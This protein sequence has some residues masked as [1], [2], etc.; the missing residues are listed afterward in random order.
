[1]IVDI[2]EVAATPEAVILQFSGELDFES[3]KSLV[4]AF[5][6]IDTSSRKYAIAEVGKISMISS[7]ALGEFMGFRKTL[8]EKDGDLVFAAMNMDIRAKFTSMGATKIFRIFNDVRSALNAFKWQ[9]GL[10]PEVINLTFPANLH[11]VPPVRQLASRIA[12]Q[13]GYGNKDS[14]RI[15]TI[16][17]EICNNA[18]EHGKKG[19]DQN[20]S[21]KIDIDQK[22]IEFDV[23]NTSDPEK[24]ETLKALL[25]PTHEQK[26]H[27]EEKRGR[28]LS[29]IK[30]L[31]DELS[32][33][34]SEKGTVV[35]VKKVR[36]V[37]NG[38]SN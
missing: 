33:D 14:F 6:K 38:I 12:K 4:D 32:V 28:G 27:S 16:I 22:Q 20:I 24:L 23:I 11:L 34:C 30:M 18:I 37:K 29:L 3:I 8:L 2:K 9:Q 10:V 17:D 31:S 19:E 25:K 26:I 7:A 36:E 15:E 1:M 5:K 35:H 21:V 13:K